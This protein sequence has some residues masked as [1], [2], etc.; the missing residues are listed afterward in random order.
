MMRKSNKSIIK[1]NKL[2]KKSKQSVDFSQYSL[3]MW[4]LSPV[5]LTIYMHCALPISILIIF[6]VK[7]NQWSSMGAVAKPARQFSHRV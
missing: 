5:K 4:D 6:N 1:N 2:K 7:L 3:K